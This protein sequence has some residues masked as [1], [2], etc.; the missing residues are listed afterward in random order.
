MKRRKPG[1][2]ALIEYGSNDIGQGDE[3]ED[4]EMD[5]NGSWEV[6]ICIVGADGDRPMRPVYDVSGKRRST[7]SDANHGGESVTNR[8]LRDRI[9]HA[10]QS[11]AQAPKT[12]VVGSEPWVETYES[13]SKCAHITV[14]AQKRRI[15]NKLERWEW[16]GTLEG[17]SIE[18]GG[19][20]GKGVEMR[21]AREWEKRTPK[22]INEVEGD[23]GTTSKGK[24]SLPI[25]GGFPVRTGTT[26]S[27]QSSHQAVSSNPAPDKIMEPRLNAKKAREHC[28]FSDITRAVG[29]SSVPENQ[30][31]RERKRE[32]LPRYL[33]ADNGAREKAPDH[34]ATAP[35]AANVIQFVL[36]VRPV[37]KTETG[38]PCRGWRGS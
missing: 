24:T 11:L 25:G 17:T 32:V 33:H 5:G 1:S 12:A 4:G 20:R 6:M 3:G 23:W 35:K 9:P 38:W 19:N 28:A 34:E 18:N 26:S 37:T 7:E 29:A 36:M 15:G 31:A 30:H 14:N 2:K 27:L 16:G 22:K 8:N 21:T 10:P 13:Q